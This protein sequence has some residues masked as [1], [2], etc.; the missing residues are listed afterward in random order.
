MMKGKGEAEKKGGSDSRGSD[1]GGR[2]SRG[3][4]SEGRD[5]GGSNSG[6]RSRVSASEFI[7]TLDNE[8]HF[9]SHLEQWLG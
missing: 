4:D 5:S 6:G 7:V 8:F 1:S 9:R 2:D 3:R